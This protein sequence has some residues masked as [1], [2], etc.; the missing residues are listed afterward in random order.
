MT[1]QYT[2]LSREP[3]LG[4]KGLGFNL[5]VAPPHN[6]VVP[7][8]GVMEVTEVFRSRPEKTEETRGLRRRVHFVN[9][10]TD[11]IIHD[12]FI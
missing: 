11:P 8:F 2:E 12:S 1:E 6:R 4:R 9:I 3:E 5:Y 10:Q 7:D